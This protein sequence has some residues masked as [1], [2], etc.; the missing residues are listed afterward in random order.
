VQGVRG[1]RSDGRV[2]AKPLQDLRREL[3]PVRGVNQIMRDSGVI[4]TR[5]EQRIERLEIA[6]FGGN[7]IDIFFGERDQRERV[8]SADLYI[9]G[10]CA[11]QALQL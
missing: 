4:G 5:L 1:I 11:W 6:F 9:P 10:D 7:T 8:E 2:A 3:R